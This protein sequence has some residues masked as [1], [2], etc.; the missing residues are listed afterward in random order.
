MIQLMNR[1]QRKFDINPLIYHKLSFSKITFY[2][3]MLLKDIKQYEYLRFRSKRAYL[4]RCG[5]LCNGSK[6]YKVISRAV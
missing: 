5:F 1:R 2:V 6:D 4:W 3:N